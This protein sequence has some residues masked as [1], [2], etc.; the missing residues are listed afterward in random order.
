MHWIDSAIIVLFF[1]AMF[2]VALLLRRRSARNIDSYFLGDRSMSWWMLGA[3]GMASNVDMAGTMLIAALIF[4]FGFAGFYIEL[5]GG[6]VLIMA[7][8][9]AY[10]GKWTRRSGKMTVAEWMSFRFGDEQGTLPRVLN[11]IYN[12]LFFVWA[13]AYF[14]VATNKFFEIFLLDFVATADLA[15]SYAGLCSVGLILIVM[16]YTMLS[17]FAGVVWTDILQGGVILFLSI[18]ISIRAFLAVD[19]DALSGLVGP[20]WLRIVPPRRL[21]VPAGYET[22]ELFQLALGFYLLKTVIDGLSGAGGYLA[23]RYFAARDERECGLL[24]LFWILLMSFR[25]PLIMGIAVLGLTMQAR[26]TDPELVLPVVIR[27]SLPVG[28]RGIMMISLLG[29]AMSTYSSFMNAGS[30]YFVK[31]IYQRYLRRT[32]GDGELVWIGYAS[33]VTFVVLG[34]IAAYQYT[35]I[36]DVWG[37]LN[38]GLGAGLILPNFLRWYWHRFNGYGYAAGALLGMAAAFALASGWLGVALN[39]YETFAAICVVALAGMIVVSWL[40]PPVR[41]DTLLDFYRTTRPF[42]LWGPIRRQLE[43]AS[44]RSIR[45]ESVRDVLAT[46]F[47]VPWQL[48]LFLL[49][50]A[51]VIHQWSLAGLLLVV[52][53][54]LSIGLYVTWYRHLRSAPDSPT[55]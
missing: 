20:D 52:L 53:V 35:S 9:L 11:A 6:I 38:M 45:R 1:I 22:F 12:L 49:P 29:A 4:T 39:E 27:A 30:S 33:T 24:S 32:A 36:N 31:D 50:M 40:T 44:Q 41:N 14:A 54:I 37:W 17:G 43:P 15:R 21:D 42:G 3:S 25:W 46:V 10:M 2:I 19:A 5:R 51:I 47:A 26:V 16:L 18:Y 23:Q 55:W 13:I 7:F 8:Y 34:L 28:I 48:V